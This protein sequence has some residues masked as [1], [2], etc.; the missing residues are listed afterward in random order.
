[1]TVIVETP[2][3]LLRK[4]VVEDAPDIFRINSD[5][6]VVRY[7]EGVTPSS[8]DETLGHLCSGPL[9][10]YATYGY[11]RWAVVDRLTGRLVGM[12]G[13]KFLAGLG[14]IE[15]GYRLERTQW[16]LGLATEAA[17]AARDHAH[18]VLGMD[19]LIALIMEE[20]AASLRVAEKLGMTCTGPL[21]YEGT[22]VLRYEIV[23]PD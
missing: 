15:I 22:D 3:L 12:C 20:N 18:D 10:D 7:A 9:A 5:P 23:F 2:R 16:G 14:E 6:Q 8:V 19:R 1:M 4:F 11:G 21:H 17:L 13:P